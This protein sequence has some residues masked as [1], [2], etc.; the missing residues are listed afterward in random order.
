MTTNKKFDK[1]AEGYNDK[2][3]DAYYE[4]NPGV[5]KQDFLDTYGFLVSHIEAVDTVNDVVAV[6]AL[7]HKL[8][9]A[10]AKEELT[11]LDA[12]YELHEVGA[13]DD[14]ELEE[15]GMLWQLAEMKGFL[16]SHKE[17]H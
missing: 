8:K 1:K 5:W 13:I 4:A 14:K 7:F 16:A 15:V 11:L 3:V 6:D 12:L 10:D 9:H 17:T 2:Q